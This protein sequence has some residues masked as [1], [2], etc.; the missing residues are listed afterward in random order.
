MTFVFWNVASS[1]AAVRLLARLARRVTADVVVLAECP[2]PVEALAE[3]N[4][5]GPDYFFVPGRSRVELFTRFP[6]TDIPAVDEQ[7]L[8]TIRRIGLPDRPELL[9]AAGH[10]PSRLHTSDA[11]RNETCREFARRVQSAEHLAGHR[12]TLVIGDL[13]LDP[14]EPGV[15]FAGGLHAASDRRIAARGGRVVQESEYPFFYNPMWR[16]FGDASQP[17]G[18]YYH[19]RADFSV[20]FWH[21][22]D[23]VLL[24]PALLPYF[25]D[26]GLTVPTSIDG[27]SLLDDNGCPDRRAASDHL[28][29]VLRLEF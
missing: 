19:W 5:D 1:P 2:D 7:H 16:F 29:V 27:T 8:F 11:G 26:D 6:D 3:L 12:N 22:F 9:L 10:L 4:R 18:T 13:N 24:R 28:P 21:V 20:H 23:Q 25:R 17:A 15:A 14:F